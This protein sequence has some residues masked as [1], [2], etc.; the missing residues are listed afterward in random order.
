MEAENKKK[1]EPGIVLTCW[2]EIQVSH[3]ISTWM[4]NEEAIV[5]SRACTHS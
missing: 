1:I 2:V 4:T 3:Q 5:K